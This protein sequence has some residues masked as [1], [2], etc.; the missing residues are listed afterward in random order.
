MAEEG[1]RGTGMAEGEE[2]RG[3]ARATGMVAAKIK[4]MAAATVTAVVVARKAN[5]AAKTVGAATGLAKATVD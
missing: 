4:E 1:A 3:P 5:A 2:E